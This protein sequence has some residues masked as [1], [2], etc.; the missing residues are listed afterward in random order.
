MA[1]IGATTRR[2]HVWKPALDVASARTLLLLHGTGADERDLL[3][4]GKALDPQ[5]NLLSP[6]GLVVA[7]GMSRFFLRYPDGR[8]DEAGIVANAAELAEFV[9]AA[10]F[11]YGFD[12][13]NVWAVGFSNGANA[14]GSMLLL[15][16][17]A[18]QG[19][20]AFGTT[21]SFVAPP[22]RIPALAG[23]KVFIANGKQD[24]YSP[25]EKTDAMVREFRQY[26]AQVELMMHS[27]GHTISHEH[28]KQIAA[29]LQA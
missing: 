10:A 4:L 13:S 22:K 29:A 9:A 16:P 25:A 14:A 20:V 23:K 12:D 11:E 27:G 3:G 5:A 7:D 19:I 21:K 6:R 2:P 26:G 8:F 15:H 24:D 18:L 1:G 17:D 28:V